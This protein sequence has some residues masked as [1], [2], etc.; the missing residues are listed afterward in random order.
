MELCEAQK[1]LYKDKFNTDDKYE[2]CSYEYW[3][4]CKIRTSYQIREID[5]ILTD[6]NSM[7]SEEVTALEEAY[8]DVRQKKAD[9]YI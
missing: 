9:S 2:A 5:Y 4:A 7:F 6:I 3:N 1:K 8:E